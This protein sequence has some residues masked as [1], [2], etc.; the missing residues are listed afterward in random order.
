MAGRECRPPEDWDDTI[1]PKKPDDG[2]ATAESDAT[3]T[4]GGPASEH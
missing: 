2:S 1:E 4:I 3:G